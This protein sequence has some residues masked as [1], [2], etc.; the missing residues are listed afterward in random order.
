[1]MGIDH[2]PDRAMRIAANEVVD[3]LVA[4]LQVMADSGR[5]AGR[6]AGRRFCDLEHEVAIAQELDMTALL[7]HLR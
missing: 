6:S 3:F 7:D 2:D 4:E 1:M 5:D